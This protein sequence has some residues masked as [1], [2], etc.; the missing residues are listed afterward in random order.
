MS[1][2]LLFGIVFTIS[3]FLTWLVRFYA[4]RKSILDI[5]NQRSSHSTPT[6]RGGGLAMV[7]SWFVGLGYLFLKGQIEQHLFF[8]LFSG[9]ILAVVSLLDD[10]MDLSPKIRIAA[11]AISALG[12][13]FFLGGIDLFPQINGVVIFWMVNIVTFVGIIWFINLYNFL[14]GID[15]YASQEAILVATGL[16]IITGNH[17]LGVLIAA[18]GGF[19]IWNWPKAK[20]FMGD[21]GSTQL[22]FILVVFG[23]YFQNNG[24]V[25]I[26]TWLVLTSVFWFDATYTLYRRWR[27]KEKLTE[28]HKKHAYQRLIQG[29]FSH[30]KVDLLAMGLNIFLLMLVFLNQYFFSHGLYLL[31]IILG[32]LSFVNARVD[33]IFPFKKDQ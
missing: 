33:R 18:V 27:N 28:A 26:Y 14:D 7:I 12:A 25:D 10:I 15:G 6:P 2:V 29:G 19:L 3:F 17:V 5:P 9:L 20:I 32:L 4:I 21:V 13:L 24:I 8:A 22:G 16:L 23:V 31:L 30:L 11:Q 1:F